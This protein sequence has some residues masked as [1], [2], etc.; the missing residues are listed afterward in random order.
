MAS[1]L[2]RL[3]N[4]GCVQENLSWSLVRFGNST[5]ISHILTTCQLMPPSI[6]RRPGKHAHNLSVGRLSRDGPRQ[7]HVHPPVPV[8]KHGDLQPK[9]RETI[10]TLAYGV[11]IIKPI[12]INPVSPVFI[13]FITGDVLP[14]VGVL[15]ILL[16]SRRQVL[17]SVQCIYCAQPTISVGKTDYSHSAYIAHIAR[18]LIVFQSCYEPEACTCFIGV[19]V[20]SVPDNLCGESVNLCCLNRTPTYLAN[21][22]LL[23]FSQKDTST[24]P[25]SSSRCSARTTPCEILV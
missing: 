21:I 24:C 7:M 1:Q 17:M 11:E 10:P 6:A 9:R 8:A 5:N 14:H 16:L 25:L 13:F 19:C 22:P 2:G 4:P 23:R 15:S 18:P 12:A 20:N 3:R